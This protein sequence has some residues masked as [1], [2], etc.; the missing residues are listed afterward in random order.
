MLVLKFY[1]LHEAMYHTM[2]M[3]RLDI[4]VFHLDRPRHLSG[5]GNMYP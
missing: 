5:A 1:A 3:V 2:Y 4:C